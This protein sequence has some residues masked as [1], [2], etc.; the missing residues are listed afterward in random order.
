VYS[1]AQR[2]EC[3]AGSTLGVTGTVNQNVYRNFLEEMGV[4]YN[5][6]IALINRLS[7]HCG[8]LGNNQ[9]IL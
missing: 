3:C 5:T 2:R 1:P 7:R 6:G 8:T 4:G 9:L